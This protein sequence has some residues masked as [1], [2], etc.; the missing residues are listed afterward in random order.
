MAPSLFSSSA[1]QFKHTCCC[2]CCCLYFACLAGQLL[3]LSDRNILCLSVSPI[4][5]NGVT[6]VAVGSADH[7]V[8]TFALETGRK[9]R[10]LYSKRCGHGEW[11]SQV[12]HTSGAT[13]QPPQ[14]LSGGDD[15]KLCL[16][17]ASGVS[18]KDLEPRHSGPVSC[19][20][21]DSAAPIAVS[22]SYDKTIRLWNVAADE[23]ASG[24]N[25]GRR[26]PSGGGGGGGGGGG[27]QQQHPC[28]VMATA[29]A[30]K[31]QESVTAGLGEGGWAEYASSPLYPASALEILAKPEVQPVLFEAAA[32][33][34]LSENQEAW[35]SQMRDIIVS[36]ASPGKQ[37]RH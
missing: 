21:C 6:E 27:E 24:R 9:L 13:G 1:L 16:W 28:C 12:A 32:G 10:T 4:T 18:C 25:S 35:E 36:F 37:R 5:R 2:C 3:D 30:C 29:S 31:F 17:S 7:G 23:S 11:C 15:G 33:R 14:V 19:L 34:K 20:R 26:E 8:Y 22:G